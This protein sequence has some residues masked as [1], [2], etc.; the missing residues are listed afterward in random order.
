MVPP[1]WEAY[2]KTAKGE[3]PVVILKM[4]DQKQRSTEWPAA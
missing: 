1:Y 3:L 4:L 2:Q